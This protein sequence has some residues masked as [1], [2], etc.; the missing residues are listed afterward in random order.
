[1]LLINAVNLLHLNWKAKYVSGKKTPQLNA[2][3][4]RIYKVSRS[5]PGQV[6]LDHSP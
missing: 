1:M 3:D 6:D 2:V 4:P 5:T